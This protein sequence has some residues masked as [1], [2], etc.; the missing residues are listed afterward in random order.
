LHFFKNEELAL[1]FEGFLFSNTA[2]GDA[3]QESKPI[4]LPASA[5][6]YGESQWEIMSLTSRAMK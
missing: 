6:E 1:S 5:A 2:G 4:G 3:A